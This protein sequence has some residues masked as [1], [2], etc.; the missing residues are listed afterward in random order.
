MLIIA[1]GYT[2]RVKMLWLATAGALSYPF[3]LLHPRTGYSV[4]RN[5]YEETNLPASILIGGTV[6]GLLAAAWLVHRFV[7]RPLAPLI[8]GFVLDRR[9][10]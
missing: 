5:V 6:L 10:Q 1:L 3:Y 4:I 9:R 8:R 7:E 2:D